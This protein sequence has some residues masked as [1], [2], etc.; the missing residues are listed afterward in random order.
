M[1]ASNPM[2]G[3]LYCHVSLDGKPSAAICSSAGNRGCERTGIASS[4][5]ESR[6]PRIGLGG[7]AVCLAVARIAFSSANQVG[8]RTFS[9]TSDLESANLT[10]SVRRL[11]YIGGT[12]Q[13]GM[14][15]FK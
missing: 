7:G 9:P 2:G 4:R 14:K 8:R 12:V 1:V 10:F 13:A 6:S 5:I 15:I 11:W 3:Q